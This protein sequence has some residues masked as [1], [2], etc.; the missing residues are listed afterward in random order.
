MT[1]KT[2]NIDHP[3]VVTAVTNEFITVEILNKS[4]CAACH[5]KGVCIA[6]DESIKTI[7]I[8]QS[9]STLACDYQVGEEVKVLLKA[10][11]GAKAVWITSVVPLMLLLATIFI[12]TKIGVSELITGISVLAILA[13]YYFLIYLLKNKISKDFTFSIEKLSK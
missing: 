12:L 7:D 10:S 1:V 3:G 4:A 13:F 5:A 11:L 6:S 2:N 9:I 8:P